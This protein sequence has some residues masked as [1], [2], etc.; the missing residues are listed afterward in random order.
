MGGST[1]VF[2]IVLYKHLRTPT[3]SSTE[4]V[5]LMENVL[6]LTP[7]VLQLPS[8]QTDPNYYAEKVKICRSRR[9]DRVVKCN[10]Q[11]QYGW[12]NPS[13]HLDRFPSVITFRASREIGN[14]QLFY[15]LWTWEKRRGNTSGKVSHDM[16]YKYKISITNRTNHTN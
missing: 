13:Q 11:K 14:G 8:Q 2:T 4:I 5:K 16:D 6:E 9:V 3:K 7:N 1:L 10:V 15:S 12:K